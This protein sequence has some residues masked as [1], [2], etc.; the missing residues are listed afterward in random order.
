[1]NLIL[2]LTTWLHISC[3]SILVGG[4]FYLRFIVLKYG[5]RNGGLSEELRKT[6]ISRY[7]HLSA[8]LMSVLFVTGLYNMFS[9]MAEWKLAPEGSI[10]PHMIFGIKFLAFLLFI[11]LVSFTAVSK[12]VNES[13]R[14]KLLLTQ[15]LLG[16]VILF[17]S[18]W[19]S[20]SY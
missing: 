6:F 3:A 2:V 10:P 16:L 11:A 9:K 12:G 7:L 20:N 13:R 17:L 19:L 4:V 18:A 15:A 8:M 1:M 14:P 5:Q